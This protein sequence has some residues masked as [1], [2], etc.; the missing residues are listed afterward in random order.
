MNIE[1]I[2]IDDGSTDKSGDVCESY[3]LKDYRIK[4]FHTNN[5]GLS[6]ARNKGISIAKG[7]WIAFLDSDDW[8]ENNYLSGLVLAID[9]YQADM[10]SYGYFEEY[11]NKTIAKPICRTFESVSKEQ[12]VRKKT[13]NN[14][15]W[16]KIY[17]AELFSEIKFPEG[18]NYEDVV[19]M[20]ELFD[21]CKSIVCIPEMLIHYRRRKAS[22]VTSY[23]LDDLVDCWSANYIR[24]NLFAK[25]SDEYEIETVKGCIIAAAS[26]WCW[27]GGV[28]RKHSNRSNYVEQYEEIRVFATN[29]KRKV[30]DGEYSLFC[31]IIVWAL[32]FDNTLLFSILYLCNRLFRMMRGRKLY[33]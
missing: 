2:I 11:K 23:N 13:Y 6:A 5:K 3:A 22:I 18:R 15:V 17:K 20:F 32:K 21:C 16:N 7:T 19:L 26:V 8:V 1:I 4:V 30:L 31:K 24:Y 9:T 10:I 25:R 27:D 14:A 28:F 33:E 29:N 12:F